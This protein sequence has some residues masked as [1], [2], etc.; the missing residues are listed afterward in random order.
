[1]LKGQ[2]VIITGANRGIGNAIMRLFASNHANIWC[3]VRTCSDAFMEQANKLSEEY[4]IWMKAIMADLAKEEEVKA[5]VSTILRENVPIDIL[6]NNAGINHRGA[7]LMTSLQEM[8]QLFRINYF[9][10]IQLIQLVAK[11]MIRQKR[12]N[13]VN[14]GSA[15]G[16]EHN[17]GNFAYAGSK[18][19]LMWATQTISRELAPYHIRVN[20]VAPGVTDTEINAGNEERIKKEI[21][22]KMNIPRK[23]DPLEIAEGVLYLASEHSSFVSGHILRIDGGRF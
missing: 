19:A 18:A 3:L 6:I 1:M 11:K 8:E 15:S 12:G 4:G 23:A 20:G 2:N 14:I 21:I 17:V 9:A 16:Y 5:A 10:P 13:I 22:G 7:F